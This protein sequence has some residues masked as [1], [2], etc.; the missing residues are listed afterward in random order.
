[1]RRTVHILTV[2]LVAPWLPGCAWG[3]TMLDSTQ[4]EIIFTK[5]YG[6]RA[7][8]PHALIR[9]VD[10]GFA[11]VGT[12]GG[13][14]YLVKTD[15]N[16]DV[17]WQREFTS[18]KPPR[19]EHTGEVVLQTRD[20]GFVVAGS[21]NS[22]STTGIQMGKTPDPISPRA[23]MAALLVKYD[24]NGTVLWTKTFLDSPEKRFR[25]HFYRGI[26]VEDGYILIGQTTVEL[27]DQPTRTGRAPAYPLWVVKFNE[28][29]E[30]V[31]ERVFGDELFTAFG[32]TELYGKPV[33]DREGHLLF[34]VA[35]R[36]W[37]K[38]G[39]GGKL[40]TKLGQGGPSVRY[41]VVLKLDKS[42][43][44]I[45]RA[46]LPAA[47]TLAVA[48]VADGY[49]LVGSE[50]TF[51]RQTWVITLDHDLNQKSQIMLNASVFS[52][53]TAL[54][55]GND[56]SLL[57]VGYHVDDPDRPRPKAA[58]AYVTKDGQFQ[59]EST[60]SGGY[61]TMVDVVRG[62]RDDEFVFLVSSEFVAEPGTA[63]VKVRRR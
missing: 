25:K 24:K 49:A 6:L 22:D 53:R 40:Q 52:I 47:D 35:T 4:Y 21:T 1:M 54:P 50:H 5:S 56:G 43:V 8:T 10:S 30:V 42:G 15:A 41:T 19:Q 11:F 32:G 38:R 28:A 37:Q 31:W 18:P 7:G 26:V 3:G 29:G 34:A 27:F 39:E 60:F 58:F 2:V 33:I 44:E 13:A 23:R 17:Q 16:G 57:V 63:L 36:E 51:H 55:W 20:G 45:K 12:F 9:T 46:Q 59:D 62:A 48:P 14:A 61:T